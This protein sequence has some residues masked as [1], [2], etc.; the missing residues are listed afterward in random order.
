MFEKLKVSGKNLKLALL[1]GL[2]CAVFLSL[3]DFNAG[4]EDLRHNVLR[5]HIIAN[6]DSDADQA[7]KLKIRDRILESS[8]D[9]F[10]LSSDVDDAIEVAKNSTEYFEKIANEVI[11]EENFDYTASV[12]FGECYFETRVYDDFTL[13]AGNYESLIINLGKG[14]GKN[15]W[16][17]IFPEICLPAASDSSLNDTVNEKGTQIAKESD[18]YILRFKVVEIYEDIKNWL[19]K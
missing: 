12:S 9:L 4:C 10:E 8:G 18:R 1:F 5:L 19:K 15:W 6:S 17:V 2:I 3:S 16:C 11:A 13:P 14:E 7:L